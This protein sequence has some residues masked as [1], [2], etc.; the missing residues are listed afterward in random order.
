[1]IPTVEATNIVKTGARRHA[2]FIAFVAISSLVFYKTLS[3]LVEYSL[4]D[5]SSSHIILIPLVAFFL[6]YVGR[7]RIF[8]ITRTSLGP[9]VGLALGGMILYGLVIRGLFLQ[10]GNWPLCLETFSV[11]L[12]WVGGFFLCYGWTAFRKG[13]FPLLFLLLMIP[14]PDVVLDRAIYALQEGSTDIAYLIFRALGIP[15]LHQGFL[16][17]VPGVTIEV[18]KEC[19]SI[20]SSIALL[21]VCLL[22]AHLYLRTGWK[23]LL[24]VLVSLP[25][26]VVKNGIRIATLTLLSIYVDPG[27]LKGKLHRDRGLCFFPFG[28]RN[29]LARD[30][31]VGEIGRAP[32]VCQ[33]CYLSRESSR[34]YL[35]DTLR[36]SP[37]CFSLHSDF[38]RTQIFNFLFPAGARSWSCRGS[39]HLGLDCWYRLPELG[40]MNV[41]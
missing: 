1:M 33:S 21:I 11:I 10:E 12:V 22:A 41:V 8:A 26:S 38:Y 23:M 24:L 2:S 20:R 30:S 29:S 19:S 7:Q 3:A 14:L 13:I 18:A 34:P 32:Q 4:H 5:D 9:G 15:V 37:P 39:P 6:L 17:S 27:F 40:Q 25:L 35:P 36:T 16:L 28:T 31:V